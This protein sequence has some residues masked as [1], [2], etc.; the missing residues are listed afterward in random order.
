MTTLPDRPN[1]GAVVVDVQNAVVANVHRRDEVI[2]AT[3]TPWSSVPERR[4]SRSCGCNAREPLSP[5]PRHRRVAVRPGAGAGRARAAGP[6]ALRRRLRGHVLESELRA[7]RRSAR[8]HR[9]S[10]TRRSRSTIHGAFVRGYDTV[11]VADAHTTDDYS[12]YGLPPVEQVIA[13]TNVY[14]GYQRRPAGPR[15]RSIP[16]TWSS[17]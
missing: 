4:T 2:G 13:F 7:R 14:W 5:R 1:T 11:L 9:P 6:Q 15:R 12:A 17:M 10:P 16:P 3:S 8:R